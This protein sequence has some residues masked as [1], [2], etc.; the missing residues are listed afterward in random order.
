MSK[1][2]LRLSGKRTESPSVT[3]EWNF[4]T[5]PGGWVIASRMVNG[6]IERNRFF[7]HE[8][9][10]NLGLNIGGFLYHAQVQAQT[11]GGGA[12]AGSDL[13]LIAQ[14]PGKVRKVLVSAGQK[15][16][17]GEAL[18]LL[19]AMKMEFSVKAPFSGT[20]T[21]IHVKE[22]EQLTPGTRFLDLE[23]EGKKS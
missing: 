21:K 9:K 8:S 12:G 5:R 10:G 23:A 20:V 15:V 1:E 3:G 19:E 14:F 18:L 13:D 7:I 2:T 11:R 17:E 22:A 6:K 16:N 4:E